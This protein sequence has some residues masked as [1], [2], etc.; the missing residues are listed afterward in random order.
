MEIGASGTRSVPARIAWM[1]AGP[2]ED[3]RMRDARVGLSR[4]TAVG[5][6]LVLGAVCPAAARTQPRD[7]WG[8]QDAAL[9]D[10]PPALDAAARAEEHPGG[11]AA[12]GG[13]PGDA[14]HARLGGGAP[15]PA[16]AP[17]AAS[18]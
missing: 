17:P 12:A 15:P 13:S 4:H 1:N 9:G 7:Q 6:I 8:E 18:Q 3:S 2:A 10:A 16:G 5:V 11:G 14:S